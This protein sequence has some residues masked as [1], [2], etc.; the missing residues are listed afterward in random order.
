MVQLLQVRKHNNRKQ[1]AWRISWI[2]YSV[3]DV[4]LGFHPRRMA[5]WFP[6]FSK[7]VCKGPSN[8]IRWP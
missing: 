1:I 5:W 4:G 6:T 2:D 3:C 8:R 7:V